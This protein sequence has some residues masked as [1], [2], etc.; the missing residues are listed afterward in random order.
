M[1]APSLKY[2]AARLPDTGRGVW[3][4]PDYGGLICEGRKEK[5]RWYLRHSVDGHR[6]RANLA[7]FP[8]TTP[9]AARELASAKLAAVNTKIAAKSKTEVAQE[10][11]AEQA[12]RKARADAPNFGAAIDMY[13]AQKLAGTKRQEKT[14]RELQSFFSKYA[15]TQPRLLPPEAVARFIETERARVPSHTNT[16]VRR[17]K[18]LF[19]WMHANGWT[20]GDILAGVEVEQS[21]ERDVSPTPAEVA[22]I[23][24]A[25]DEEQNRA[26]ALFVY[27][28]AFTAQ[29]R[30][31]VAAMQAGEIDVAK[32]VWTIPAAK[33]K[34][35]TDYQTPLATSAM[36][37]IAELD[38]I[39]HESVVAANPDAYL[40]RGRP[41]ALGNP[42]SH[43][44]G[45]S[46][47]K[48]RL[49]KR[50]KDKHGDF[51]DWQFHDL[52]RAF[53]D[54]VID[55]GHDPSIVD[56]CLNHAASQ[57][58]SRIQRRYQRSQQVERQRAVFE[59]WASILNDAL[60][61]A[62]GEEPEN[63][64]VDIRHGR[65]GNE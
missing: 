53:S 26:T 47:V 19:R 39:N 23:L 59:T 48:K 22:E 44:K 13:A 15:A 63:R 5:A 16:V 11:R 24:I 8:E 57:T 1:K 9:A 36:F 45:Y 21:K 50:L 62:R 55:A 28:L 52:R 20:D 40:F 29:R 60:A 58:T 34:T 46:V 38:D 56:R 25:A 61:R 3:R 41:S 54:A 42:A 2:V 27:M 43:F 14:R 64:I 12:M 49:D 6:F 10:L 65:A 4:D 7:P 32:Y 35:A 31:N 30:E 17:A 33:A 18:P 51:I 37:A